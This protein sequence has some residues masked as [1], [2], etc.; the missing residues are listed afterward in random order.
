MR[1]LI[2]GVG[3]DLIN[4]WFEVPVKNVYIILIR[5]LFIIYALHFLI[6]LCKWNDTSMAQI[7]N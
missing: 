6:L 7:Y 2:C 3:S 5:Y 1:G 4:V